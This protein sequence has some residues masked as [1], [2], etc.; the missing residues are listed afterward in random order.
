V[1]VG[2][3]GLGTAFL[4]LLLPLLGGLLAHELDI[5]IEVVLMDQD[6]AYDLLQAVAHV[7]RLLAL[8][9]EAPGFSAR[10]SLAPHT[11]GLG[12]RVQGFGFRVRI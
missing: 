5:I 3:W 12:I 9:Q 4:G 7:V 1:G 2:G 10:T 6:L 8:R 11:P